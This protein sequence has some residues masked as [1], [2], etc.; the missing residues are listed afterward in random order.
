MGEKIKALLYYVFRHTHFL[1]SCFYCHFFIF[2]RI[3]TPV[4]N[5]KLV[6]SK[7]SENTRKKPENLGG[8]VADV[9]EASVL[10]VE[11]ARVP[12]TATKMDVGKAP[13]TEGVPMIQTGCEWKTSS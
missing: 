12:A 1:F 3:F 5:T 4:L 13:C 2:S 10:L 11:I 8:G 7:E 9:V 6:V